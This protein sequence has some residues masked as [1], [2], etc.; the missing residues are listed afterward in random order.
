MAD[1]TGFGSS[2]IG[3]DSNTALINEIMSQVVP[4]VDQTKAEMCSGLTEKAQAAEFV[5]LKQQLE[6]SHASLAQTSY[7]R[8]RTNPK[9][10]PSIDRS[11]QAKSLGGLHYRV[12]MRRNARHVLGSEPNASI[13]E[14]SGVEQIQIDSS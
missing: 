3:T 12:Q 6:K 8:P 9:M 13:Y 4:K 10:Q 7:N 2:T 1:K 14:P 5:K 11:G